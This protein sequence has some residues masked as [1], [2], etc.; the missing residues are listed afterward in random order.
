MS[1]GLSPCGWHLAD[2]THCGKPAIHFLQVKM[3]VLDICL[4]TVLAARTV[5]ATG[6]SVRLNKRF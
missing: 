2:D 6:F 1:R 3:L 5:H 4:S